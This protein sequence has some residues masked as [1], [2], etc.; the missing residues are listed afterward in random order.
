MLHPARQE[1]TGR[2]D[3]LPEDLKTISINDRVTSKCMVDGSCYEV[4]KKKLMGES[5]YFKAM[6]SHDF[7][8]RLT[9]TNPP[10][11]TEQAVQE[12]ETGCVELHDVDPRVIARVADRLNLPDPDWATFFSNGSPGVIVPHGISVH[13]FNQETFVF[14]DKYIIPELE[15]QCNKRFQEYWN[16]DRPGMSGEDDVAKFM[17]GPLRAAEASVRRRISQ[18]ALQYLRK[19]H[20]DLAVRTAQG[21][22]DRPLQTLCV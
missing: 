3:H 8:V 5:A 22:R 7:K 15:S 21:T 12:A 4:D 20:V 16:L 14:A 1:L 9:R 10:S 11:A 18:Q 13:A 19:V 17:K 6:F 2:S